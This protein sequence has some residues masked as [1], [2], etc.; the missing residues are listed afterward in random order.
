[1]KKLPIELE[2]NFDFDSYIWILK[3]LKLLP[4]FIIRRLF[5]QVAYKYVRGEMV[6]LTIINLLNLKGIFYAEFSS[7]QFDKVKESDKLEQSLEIFAA[8]WRKQMLPILKSVYKEENKIIL[9]LGSKLLIVSK[10]F[11]SPKIQK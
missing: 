3:L 7:E 2:T 1:M 11:Y 6:S 4:T 8:D 5:F 10:F 9:T